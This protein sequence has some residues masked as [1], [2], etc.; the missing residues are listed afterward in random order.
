MFFEIEIDL[1]RMNAAYAISV[2]RALKHAC[3]VGHHPPEVRT[4]R[5]FAESELALEALDGF[6]LDEECGDPEA[7]EVGELP[8]SC[9][10]RGRVLDLRGR[11][12]IG[13]EAG[14]RVAGACGYV[15]SDDL[16]S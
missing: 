15:A 5:V 13:D 4:A 9:E 10:T 14:E 1:H 7:C 3:V 12:R 16:V 6:G 8:R 2:A 11:E